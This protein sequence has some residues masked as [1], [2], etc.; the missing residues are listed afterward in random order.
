MD[1]SSYLLGKKA[2]GTSTG[3]I[4]Y[5]GTTLDGRLDLTPKQLYSYL[6][7]DKFVVIRIDTDTIKYFYYISVIENNNGYRLEFSDGTEFE[8]ED[9]NTP[10]SYK[11]N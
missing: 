11:Q 7:E 3:G 9:E 1:V 4:V 5:V 8:S 10:F 2:S 6:D